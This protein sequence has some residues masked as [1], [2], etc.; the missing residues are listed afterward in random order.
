MH[1]FDLPTCQDIK[2]IGR[3][4]LQEEESAFFERAGN[5][6]FHNQLEVVIAGVL[7]DNDF[8]QILWR[9]VHFMILHPGSVTFVL[10]EPATAAV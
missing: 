5:T 3:I 10:D 4:A 1:Q 9:E 7:E 8:A 6:I 2:E